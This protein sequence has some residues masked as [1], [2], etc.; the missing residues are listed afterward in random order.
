[1]K[2]T[3]LL[4][5]ALIITPAA[6]AGDPPAADRAAILGMAGEYKVSFSFHETIAFQ[7]GYEL[8]KP[9]T[10][11]AHELVLVA[12]DEPRHIELQHILVAEGHVIKHWRQVWT[13]EDTRVCE[14][15]GGQTWRMRDLS[16]AEAA[17]TWTQLVTQTDD[18][19]RYE[20]PGR[21][22][23]RAGV[24][25]W[26]SGHTW[27]PLP[28]REQKRSEEYHVIAGMNRHVLTPGGWVHEQDNTKTVLKDGKEAAHIARE[29]GV[30]TY[31]RITDEDKVDFAPARKMWAENSAFW[32]LVNETWLDMQ[33]TEP[34]FK[35]AG[36]KEL[37]EL[38]KAVDKLNAQPPPAP[39]QWP[40]RETIAAWL[41]R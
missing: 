11:S 32:N 17:G 35:V 9:Y 5:T 39:G 7:P 4:F 23:H 14:Y 3:T 30:N 1:M 25:T 34:V 20:S 12:K 6:F 28:R 19:P 21:W 37:R 22:E 18:S 36:P 8:R 24:S 13:F 33:R 10:E 16:A 29:T 26:T 27:R 40:V 31:A 2:Q 38:H 15:Q 41:V